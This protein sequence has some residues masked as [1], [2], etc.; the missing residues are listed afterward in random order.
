M[1][2]TVQGLLL[3]KLL[4]KEHSRDVVRSYL[5]HLMYKRKQE[6]K[7]LVLPADTGGASSSGLER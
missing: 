6:N 2:A 7:L 1:F 4:L 3:R 5:K